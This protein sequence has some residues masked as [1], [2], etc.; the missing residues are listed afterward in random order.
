MAIEWSHDEQRVFSLCSFV[1]SLLSLIGSV[2]IFISFLA[3]FKSRR[4]QITHRLVLSLSLC[5]FLLSICWLVGGP[6]DEV[7]AVA[8]QVLAPV[9]YYLFLASF[10]WTSIIATGTFYL[11]NIII[12]L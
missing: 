10:L 12:L 7:S 2:F 6:L 11:K 4:K 1:S 5:H 9:R 8:C 3:F